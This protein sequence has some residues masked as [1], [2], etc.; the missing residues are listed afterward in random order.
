MLS[1]LL[2]FRPYVQRIYRSTSLLPGIDTMESLA[3]SLAL[4][5]C[6]RYCSCSAVSSSS[7]QDP[8]PPVAQEGRLLP[9][10]PL[11]TFGNHWTQLSGT[12][13][14]KARTRSEPWPG[15]SCFSN[16]T[17]VKSIFVAQTYL[18]SSA[19]QASK[20]VLTEP[21]YYSTITAVKAEYWE[22]LSPPS[23]QFDQ[24]SLYMF[25]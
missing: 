8:P 15:K 20:L 16:R 4:C 3:L 18:K 11:P 10:A 23:A 6:R 22:V 13:F 17:V 9:G 5:S 21:Y 19:A 24:E 7:C 12:Q 2:C 1:C 25:A 14:D